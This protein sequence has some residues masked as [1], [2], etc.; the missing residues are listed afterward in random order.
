[1]KYDNIADI[2]NHIDAK[3]LFRR[4]YPHHFM[5]YGNSLCPFHHDTNG[6]LSFHNGNF[7]CFADHCGVHG[8]V[9]ELYMKIHG[10]DFRE[11]V[12]GLQAETWISNEQPACKHVGGEPPLAEAEEEIKPD[13]A[14]IYEQLLENGLIPIEA[15]LYLT[16]QR[17]LS[18][19]LVENLEEDSM[20]AWL[21][22]DHSQAI[23]F[24]MFNTAT[25]GEIVG[26]QK[27]PIFGGTKRFA[28]GTNG[29]AAVFCY[30]QSGPVVVT[31]AIIDG[32]SAM[33]CLEC[34]M[35]SIMASGGTAKLAHHK[36]KDL[37]LFFDNDNAGISATKK[38]VKLLRCQCRVVDWNLAPEGFKDINELLNGSHRDII[39]RMILEAVPP[40]GLDPDILDDNY[41]DGFKFPAPAELLNDSCQTS[42]A[43]GIKALRNHIATPSNKLARSSAGLG[44]TNEATELAYGQAKDRVVYYYLPNHKIC[45][46][47]TEKIQACKPGGDI[48]VVHLMGR[49]SDGRNGSLIVCPM[50]IQASVAM[51]K[52]YDPGEVLCPKCTLSK[53]CEYASQLEEIKKEKRGLIIAPHSY[54]PIHLTSPEEEEDQEDKLAYV[55]ENPF[56]V[57]LHP[58]EPNTIE[59][60][61]ILRPYVTS[62]C[63]HSFEILQQLIH[64]VYADLVTKKK[65]IARYYTV[66]SSVALW[67]D[68]L[69]LWNALGVSKEEAGKMCEHALTHLETMPAIFLFERDIPLTAVNWLKAAI[70]DG[71]AYLEIRDTG[72]AFFVH[73]VK[74]KVDPKAEII[75][76]DATID[77]EEAKYMFDRE[78]DTVD[79][80][81]PW[82]GRRIHIRTG[83]GITKTKDMAKS[84]NKVQ[85]TQTLEIAASHLDNPQR[86]Y[87]ATYKHHEIECG[88]I[89]GEILPST[90]VL[91]GHYGA[92]RSSNRYEDCDSA[93]L[94]GALR[95]PP[96]ARID[97][98]AMLFP[99]DPDRQERWILHKQYEEQ[100]QNAHRLRLIRNPGRTVIIVDRE[101]PAYLL[102]E[103]DLVIPIRSTNT[104]IGRAVER[105]LDYIMENLELSKEG[106]S[107]I[108][109]GFQEDKDKIEGDY[110]GLYGEELILFNDANW[111]TALTRAIQERRPDIE[112]TSL[113]SKRGKPG[114]V[115]HIQRN[116]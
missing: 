102:G 72:K 82:E 79:I 84:G 10:C 21:E 105:A 111:W 1:M 88:R 36:D 70:G 61:N 80:N 109:V 69:S 50:H 8:D 23:V 106:C 53:D 18:A 103:P 115:L 112:V 95:L 11:A 41:I 43:E 78:F 13:F 7:K 47:V 62:D 5:A 35:L 54:I 74:E 4:H 94:F 104:K 89:M 25:P 73:L 68:R 67:K 28:K 42:L 48:P 71:V 46:E 86:L 99:S 85:L 44:K 37:V 101:W 30:G 116:S 17:G 20:V 45:Q 39:K 92:I 97:A 110:D 57:M 76:L 26:Y 51:K 19:K 107:K 12:E 31:E 56:D 32:L 59:D 15:D 9:I 27:I 81:V 65:K 3:V 63:T 90:T 98:A 93:I 91:T 75:L 66:S 58:S 60:F 38:A 22:D 24:P 55:D 113:R 83:M 100:Y 14:T 16:Q 34:S 64:T 114:K 6:S 2:K 77:Y 87:L 49:S 108:G 96:D 52:G 40:S 33:D 29:A